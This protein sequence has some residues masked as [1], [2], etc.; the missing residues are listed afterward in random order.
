M[1]MESRNYM[2]R[3][4][5]EGNSVLRDRAAGDDVERRVRSNYRL[6]SGKP[7]EEDDALQAL[8][9]SVAVVRS[10]GPSFLRRIITV[11]VREYGC[12]PGIS[13]QS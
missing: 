3:M 13:V 2:I 9:L 12:H 7:I 6:L 4:P 10:A 8:D 1:A 11:L 5:R